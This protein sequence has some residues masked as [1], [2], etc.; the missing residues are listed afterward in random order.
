[1]SAQPATAMQTTKESSPVR[2]DNR[3]LLTEF[4]RIW[5]SIARRAFEL[6]EGSGRWHGHDLEDWF[7]AEAEIVHPL[8]LELKESDSRFGVR[9]EVPGFAARDLE[10]S[11]EPRRLKISGSRV[12]RGEQGEGKTLRSELRSDQILRTIDLPSDVDASKASATL[13]DG[14]L[15]IELPKVAQAKPV[16]IEPKAA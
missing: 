13:K 4:D 3:N 1:M 11:L 12:T 15:T 7:R 2:Q 10:I 9:A 14:V 8:P 16:R 6:F 5:D